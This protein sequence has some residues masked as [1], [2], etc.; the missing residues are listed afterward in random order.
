MT[1]KADPATHAT[2]V[3]LVA[4]SVLFFSLAGIFTRSV[5]A[6]AWEVIFWRGIAAAGFALVFMILRGTLMSEIRGFGRAEMLVALLGASGTAAFIP[7]LK[8]SSVANV[9][10]I[11]AAAPFLAAGLAWL[12]M[13]EMPARRTVIAS[14]IAFIGVLVTISGSLQSA[15]LLTTG[16]LGD[17]LALWMTLMMAAM[18]V[19][20][21]KRPETKVMLP[22][23]MSSVLLLPLGLVFGDVMET[24]FSDMPLLI[25]FG[26]S[27]A[28]AAVL[29]PEGARRLPAAETALLSMLETP[30][31]PVL[32]WLILF[33]LPTLQAVAGGMLILGAAAWS[34][35]PGQFW[36]GQRR[37]G[38]QGTPL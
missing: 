20:Y 31:A 11:Y 6:G 2:G 30:L 23:V 27:F 26:A 32:A 4:V 15:G 13:S 24:Q 18:M 29:L 16:L 37:K 9:A 36:P 1:L 35:T 17:T 33:E 10:L 28:V 19:V 7:A 34:Q 25:L 12:I 14:A 3:T 5:E 21:R 38:G 8:L 22:A